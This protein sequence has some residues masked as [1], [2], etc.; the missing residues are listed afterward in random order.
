MTTIEMPAR[1][2]TKHPSCTSLRK[3]RVYPAS[4]STLYI[5]ETGL[6]WLLDW[7]WDELETSG[8]AQPEETSD[9]LE[10]NCVAAGVHIRP[11]FTSQ[12]MKYEA[13]V[14]EGGQKGKV[15]TSAL[16]GMTP[17]KYNTMASIYGYTVSFDVAT[18]ED[19][20]RATRDFLSHYMADILGFRNEQSS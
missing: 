14:V 6:E 20:K 18:R 1:E 3:V 10:P 12:D 16:A 11:D 9:D 2:P 19:M 8:V 13:I 17:H 7:V 4:T 5:A 15:V